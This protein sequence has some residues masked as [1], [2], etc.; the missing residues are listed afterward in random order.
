[1][2]IGL[3]VPGFSA[4]PTDWCIPAL[5][6]LV[7]RL[8][9]TDDV[10]V[11]AVR[12]P[13]R[14]DRYAI[15]RVQVVAVGGGQRRGASTL[16]VWRRTLGYLA[17]EHRR[18]PF[19]VLH[20]FWATESGFLTALAGPAL[21]VPTI[22]SLAGGELVGLADIGYGDQLAR[23]QRLK[24]RTSLRLA[25]MVTAGSRYQLRL[26]RRYVRRIYL[27]PLGVDTQLF[28]PGPPVGGE[29][30]I[31]HVGALTPVKD[32][33]TLLHT[34]AELRRRLPG[35]RL[36]IVG[37]GPLRQELRHLATRLGIAE[38]THFRGE[39]AH[40]ALPAVYQAAT[41]FALSSRHEAQGMVALEAAACGRPVVGTHVGVLP[42]LAPTAPVGD[43]QALADGLVTVCGDPRRAADLGCATRQLV[44]AEYSLDASA[45]RFRALYAD[46][47]G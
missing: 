11:V 3:V 28:Q 35:A 41:V 25:R 30:H 45:A 21:R 24:V 37:D 23:A 38:A 20:A 17:S 4:D 40:D 26:A 10:L 2:R 1:M 43:A 6:H 14:V 13:Y 33:A 36:D 32:Q 31:V 46:L 29:P 42:D 18:R 7:T 27:A 39:V 5:R 12:Y 9:E 16:D 19:D 15:G 34:F 47:S 44:E 22:V 8:S